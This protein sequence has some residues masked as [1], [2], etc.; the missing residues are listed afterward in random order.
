[1]P[2]TCKKCGWSVWVNDKG[3]CK[4]CSDKKKYK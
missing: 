1:M 3:Y 4:E 2:Q